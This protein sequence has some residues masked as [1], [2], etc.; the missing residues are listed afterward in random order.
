MEDVCCLFYTDDTVL[1]SGLIFKFHQILQY[2][3]YWSG[4]N[5]K[6]NVEK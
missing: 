1:L 5:L 3:S 6:F 4:V 2:L